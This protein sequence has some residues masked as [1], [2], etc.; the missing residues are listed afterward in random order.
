MSLSKVCV[1]RE[2]KHDPVV[3]QRAY[4][5]VMHG[6]SLR[7]AQQEF[8]LPKSTIQDMVKRGGIE[9]KGREPIIPK[10]RRPYS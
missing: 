5:A 4:D 2:M 7:G 10:D 8:K 3:M 6:M 9:T 1:K